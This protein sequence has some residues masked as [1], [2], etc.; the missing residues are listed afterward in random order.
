MKLKID[1]STLISEIY[2]MLDLMT[3]TDIENLKQKSI[4][5]L[6]KST[7]MSL[8]VG[9]FI[10]ASNGKVEALF[11]TFEEKRMTAFQ[12]FALMAFADFVKDFL[13]KLGSFKIPLTSEENQAADGLPEF[14][15][16]E[17]LILY[18]FNRFKCGSLYEAEQRTLS[19]ILLLKKEDYINRMYEKKYNAIITKK[20]KK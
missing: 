6:F 15:L 1:K 8:T 11:E 5:Q 16:S 12:Y 19:E 10:N 4:D 9:Q 18:S 14:T 2:P 13:E 3:E 7:F 17:H 20:Y